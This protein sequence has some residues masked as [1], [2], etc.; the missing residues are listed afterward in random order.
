M[1]NIKNEIKVDG[2]KIF[3]GNLGYLDMMESRICTA[4]N[5]FKLFHKLLEF[6]SLNNKRENHTIPDTVN[7]LVTISDKKIYSNIMP[8]LVAL[9]I[10]ADGIIAEDQVDLATEL[11]MHEELID[12]KEEAFLLIKRTMDDMLTYIDKS[13]FVFQLKMNSLINEVSNINNK[14]HKDR[15]IIIIEG[16]SKNTKGFG[17]METV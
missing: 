8:K 3:F 15:L 12:E 17:E 7:Q 5:A 13:F 10:I 16:M 14:L 9:F 1:I 2:S 4:K 6:L 11:I